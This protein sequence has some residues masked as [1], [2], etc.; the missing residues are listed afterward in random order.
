MDINNSL[1]LMATR[2]PAT[3]I[4]REGETTYLYVEKIGVHTCRV[5]VGFLFQR[6]LVAIKR[7]DQQNFTPPGCAASPKTPPAAF[8][9]S[10]R[11][12]SVSQTLSE[13]T[14]K[15]AARRMTRCRARK[16]STWEVCQT[17][18]WRIHGTKCIFSK[19]LHTSHQDQLMNVGKFTIVPWIRHG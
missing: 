18:P 14:S 12:V 9:L 16:V 10:T 3:V 5:Q 17:N 1:L 6:N 4:S 11:L 15:V 2:N 8:S 13:C 7:Y 19:H